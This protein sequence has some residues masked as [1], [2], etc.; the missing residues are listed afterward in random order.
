MN[1]PIL[2]L[3][4]I[5]NLSPLIAQ[6]YD[7]VK[8]K[9]TASAYVI[10]FPSN[11]EKGIEDVPTVKGNVKMHTYT[12]QSDDT[13]D[14]LIYMA[15]FTQYPDS[16]F[17]DGLKTL[18]K[19]NIA[20]DNAVSGAVTNVKGTLVSKSEIIFNGFNGRDAKIGLESGGIQYIIKMKTILVG[21]SL[22]SAQVICKKENDDNLN[23]KYFFN[24]FELINVKQ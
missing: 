17:P 13:D 18:E 21:T 24:S 11:P 4:F 12:Y 8:V 9:D 3:F 23:S 10:E 22:Y 16:F 14:N 19:R 6:N 2:L 7:W 5:F 15:F 1:K 20:L